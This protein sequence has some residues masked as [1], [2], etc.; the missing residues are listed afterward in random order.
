MMDVRGMG[1]T[2]SLVKKPIRLSQNIEVPENAAINIT[3]AA[4]TPD[5]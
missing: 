4:T 2:S 5:A 3:E 1:D